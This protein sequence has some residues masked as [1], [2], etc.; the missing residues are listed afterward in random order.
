[1]AANK[2][3]RYLEVLVR[4]MLQHSAGDSSEAN[5]RSAQHYFEALCRRDYPAAIRRHF[6]RVQLREILAEV[7]RALPALNKQVFRTT[8]PRQLG[9]MAADLGAVLR[10]DRFEGSEG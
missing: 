2:K 9:K 3:P 7:R 5:V 6:D 4:E 10:V 1:M 8:D